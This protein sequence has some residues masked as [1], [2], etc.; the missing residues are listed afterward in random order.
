MRLEKGKQVKADRRVEAEK[1]RRYKDKFVENYLK[2]RDGGL[3]NK[4]V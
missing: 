3:S 1:E 4:V 2:M